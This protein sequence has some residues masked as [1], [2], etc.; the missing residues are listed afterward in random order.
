[1]NSAYPDRMRLA[2]YLA[3]AALPALVSACGVGAAS[4]SAEP[5]RTQVLAR[6]APASADA[7]SPDVAGAGAAS[8][9]PTKVLVLIEENHSYR[10]MRRQMPY[11]YNLATRYAYASN[12]TAIRHPSLPNYLALAG[13]STFGVTD[14]NPPAAHPITR[15]SV[16]DQALNVG[17]TAKTYAESMPTPCALTSSGNY[18]VKHNPW[19]YF[20]N[21]RARCQALDVPLGPADSGPLHSDAI[22]GT[23]PNVGFAIPNLCNDA[24]DCTLARADGWLKQRLPAILSGPDFTAGRLV[25]V[26][27]ADEDDRNSGNHVLTVVLHPSLS[28]QVVSTPLTHYSLLGYL[29]HVLGVHLLGHATRGFARAFGL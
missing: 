13:G 25:V 21:S 2:R 19:A 10:Q 1:M 8:A 20:A 22:T 27:T 16:F 12:Y 18:A 7:V 28:R 26:I 3:L 15:R 14:D 9:T 5:S 4:S 6:S 24:H 17:K 11:L 29:D 23:L